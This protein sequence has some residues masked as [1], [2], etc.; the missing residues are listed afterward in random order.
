[1]PYWLAAFAAVLAVVLAYRRAEHRPVAVF[2]VSMV[3]L[4]VARLYLRSAFHL[5]VPGPYVGAQRVAFHGDEAGFLA[6]PAGLA[7]LALA[8]FD[9]RRRP[10]P[11]ALA[12][13]VVWVALVALYPS[14]LVRGDG[15]RR[16][17]LAAFLT[18]LAVVVVTLVR[19]TSKKARPHSEHAVMFL[20]GAA[21]CVRLMS[22]SGAIAPQWGAWMPPGN[23]VLYAV[24]A[25]V[26]GV[27]LWVQR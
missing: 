15:L 24:I 1:M 3:V 21:E 5:D 23:G 13:A 12:W 6:W 11:P 25:A 14:D 26:Q 2:L 8:V 17:Y 7:A 27:F 22:F 10:W 18:G 19:W 4:D 9:G 16:V 20:L